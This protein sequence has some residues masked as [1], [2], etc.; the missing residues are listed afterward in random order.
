MERVFTSQ[1]H[2]LTCKMS[3]CSR[4]PLNRWLPRCLKDASKG[5]WVAQSA[6]RPTL[7]FSSGC[8]LRV[9]RSSPELGSTL[10]WESTGHSLSPSTPSL[11]PC[12]CTLSCSLSL[13]Q[14]INKRCWHVLRCHAPQLSQKMLTVC[15]ALLC[16]SILRQ[17]NWENDQILAL[18]V[19][20]AIWNFSW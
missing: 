13:S 19:Q 15:A 4:W 1:K 16:N 17:R 5:T 9:M 2:S 10:S 11:H 14:K 3:K 12:L 18:V 8:D 20:F 7:G 6:K